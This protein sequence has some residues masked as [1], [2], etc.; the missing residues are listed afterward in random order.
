MKFTLK[1][2]KNDP[3]KTYVSEDGLYKI[4][5]RPSKKTWTLKRVSLFD[6]MGETIGEY[7]T[8]EEAMRG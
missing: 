6:I 1:S 2:S 4:T 8:L 3:V 5:K 7:N